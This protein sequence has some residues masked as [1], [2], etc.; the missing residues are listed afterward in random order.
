M[1]K[2]DEP[3]GG[4]GSYDRHDSILFNSVAWFSVGVVGSVTSARRS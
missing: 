4:S 3:T 1:S 2:K